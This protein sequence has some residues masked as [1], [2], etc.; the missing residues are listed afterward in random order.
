[1]LVADLLEHRP[2]PKIHT[3]IS[4]DVFIRCKKNPKL[5]FF[6]PD[7]HAIDNFHVDKICASGIPVPLLPKPAQGLR[8]VAC[9]IQSEVGAHWARMP[10][11]RSLYNS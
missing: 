4:N 5:Q 7:N 8:A 6:R 9:H 10:M 11:G 2:G 1:M 3:N